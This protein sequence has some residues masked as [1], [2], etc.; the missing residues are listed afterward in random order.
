MLYFYVGVFVVG[1]GL[2]VWLEKSK[3]S[4]QPKTLA[5]HIHEIVSQ[6]TRSPKRVSLVTSEDAWLYTRMVGAGYVEIINVFRDHTE[7]DSYVAYRLTK[8]GHDMFVSGKDFPPNLS[9]TEVNP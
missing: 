5:L 3:P 8:L 4:N 7:G 2:G 1:F 6:L 9:V